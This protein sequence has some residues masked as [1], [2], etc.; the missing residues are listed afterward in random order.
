MTF[1]CRQSRCSPN[2][3]KNIIVINWT[4]LKYICLISIKFYPK[5]KFFFPLFQIS[6]VIHYQA[7]KQKKVSLKARLK[8]SN[9]RHIW[10][11]S[12]ALGC[13]HI[14]PDNEKLQCIVQCVNTYMYPTSDSRLQRSARHNCSLSLSQPQ[15]PFFF[16]CVN[17]SPFRYDFGGDAKAICHYVNLT[18][19]FTQFPD[20]SKFQAVLSIDKFEMNESEMMHSDSNTCMFVFQTWILVQ[21]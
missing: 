17:R 18:L 11:R 5:L 14:I 12:C 6:H 1:I 4:I 2:N 20:N 15:Q 9:M 7:P 10:K 13:G 19:T 16:V 8:F 3:N 21:M